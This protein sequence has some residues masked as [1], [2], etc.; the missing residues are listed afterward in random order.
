VPER[1]WEREHY[2]ATVREAHEHESLAG[3]FARELPDPRDTD[4]GDGLG[5]TDGTDGELYDNESA[6]PAGDVW[7]TSRQPASGTTS[8]I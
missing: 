7:S 2:G 6:P 3:R 8:P 1:P 5:D 4:V